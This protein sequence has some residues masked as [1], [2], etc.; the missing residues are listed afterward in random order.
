ME[1]PLEQVPNTNLKNQESNN[2][3]ASK[4]QKTEKEKLKEEEKNLQ[5]NSEKSKNMKN[6]PK[7]KEKSQINEVIVEEVPKNPKN[8]IPIQHSLKPEEIFEEKPDKSLCYKAEQELPSSIQKV[9]KSDNLSESWAYYQFI[10]RYMQ[11]IYKRFEDPISEPEK[12]APL[13]TYYSETYKSKKIL[14]HSED[15]VISCEVKR[16]IN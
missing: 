2:Q 10:L 7:E 16:V 11:K 5:E 6:L 12:F 1:Y 9:L 4:I 13:L 8:M 3:S 15:Y 14:T